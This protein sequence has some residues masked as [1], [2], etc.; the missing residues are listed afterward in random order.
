MFFGFK[1]KKRK[2]KK[3]RQLLEAKRDREMDSP[4]KPPRNTAPSTF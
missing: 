3:Y 2:E 1:K 4:L